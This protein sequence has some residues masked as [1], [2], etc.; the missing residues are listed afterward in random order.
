MKK[1]LPLICMISSCGIAVAN[2]VSPDQALARL[3]KLSEVKT[4]S[5]AAVA[6]APMELISTEGNLYVFTSGEGFVV[7]PADDAAPALLAFSDTGRF[8][9]TDN[10]GLA[11]WMDFYN[12]QL[13]T[14]KSRSQ[15]VQANVASAGEVRTKRADIAPLL[16]TEWNQ[17]S[18]YNELCPKVDGRETVTG[19]VATAMAQAM[20]FY[21][22]P[23]HGKGSH[24]YFWRPGEEELTFDY[25]NTTFEWDLMTDRYDKNSSEASRHAVAQLMLGCGISVDMH[26]E[27][28]E[29]GAATMAMGT[30]LIDIFGYSPALWMPNRSFYG[31][32]EW[33]DMIYEE[34][35]NNHPVLYSGAG[36]AGGHQFICDGYRDGGYF[37]FNWGW[38]GLSNGYFLLNALNPAD[39]G[40]GG[41]AGGFN[42]SQ[43]ATLGMR[44]AADGDKPVYLF[45]N[46]IAFTTDVKSVKEGDDFRCGGEY[47]NYSLYTMPDGSRLGMRFKEVNGTESFYAEGPD[48]AGYHPDDGRYDLQVRFPA[49]ADGTYEITPA[50]KVDGRWY[51]VRMPV[52]LSQSVTAV[53]QDKVATITNTE[54]AVIKI[55][56]ITIPGTIYR[57]HDFP[58]TFKAQ[59]SSEAEYYGSVTPTLINA[60]GTEVAKSQFRPLDVIPS[61]DENVTDYIADFEALKDQEFPAGEYKLV[62]KDESG[63]TVSDPISVTVDIMTAETAFTITDFKLDDADPVT[64]PTKVT[65][66]FTLNCTSGVFFSDVEL[67]IF[68]GDGGYDVY[69]KDS[70]RTYLTA[71]ESAHSS[72]EADLQDLKDGEYLALIYSSGKAVSDRVYFKLKR[73]SSGIS[74]ITDDPASEEIYD[75]WG[76]KLT[77]PLQ[78][79]LY[80]INGKKVLIH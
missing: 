36:T 32:Y 50:L 37:H 74:E 21:N 59:N 67:V 49:L 52:G 55:T 60:D 73:D 20:K 64:D 70:D 29:S 65:F 58:L 63:Q 72:V 12:S 9:C 38:G 22:Y 1:I 30:A 76:H 24:S 5:R 61:S 39:L 35:S 62:F 80:I 47:F 33:E 13:E 53:V 46:T 15:T 79:G 6:Q 14:L 17:E 28:G 23:A 68:P 8:D 11:Y 51:D 77:R 66:S 26:Y 40:V 41:G 3:S 45:Y 27:P 7:L 4:Y 48:V 34:L 71:G 75:L 56:D 44:P 57:N 2:P 19:C 25:E 18:P 42:T 54:G 78:P 31:Y 69:H 10:P 43:V 16:T